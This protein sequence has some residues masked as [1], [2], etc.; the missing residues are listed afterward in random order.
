M[1]TQAV[2]AVSSSQGPQKNIRRLLLLYVALIAYSSL[3]PW[4][5]VHDP[6][7]TLLLPVDL[8]DLRDFSRDFFVNFWIYVPMGALAYWSFRTGRLTRWIAPAGI[9]FAVSL[10]VELLQ[11][12]VPTRVS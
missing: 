10:T 3:Y 4:H 8:S 11:Y 7:H 1:S 12:Y 2:R 6:G 9:G 5:F